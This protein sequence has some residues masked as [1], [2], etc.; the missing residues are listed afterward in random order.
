MNDK[1]ITELWDVKNG[2]AREFDYDVEKLAKFLMEKQ[3]ISKST[4]RYD[5]LASSA[6]QDA[7]PD[8]GVAVNS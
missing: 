4:P 6:E 1:I 8:P 7:Q 5:A 3:D 2:I